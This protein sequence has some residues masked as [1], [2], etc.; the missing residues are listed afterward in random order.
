MSATEPKAGSALLLLLGMLFSLLLDHVPCTQDVASFL[1]SARLDEVVLDGVARGGG[2][3]VDAELAVDVAQV[4][5]HG[6]GGD[7]ELL[8]DL[9]AGQALGDQAQDGDLA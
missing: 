5:A 4:G 1:M 7:D 3:G 6:D 2:T 8:C 9:G